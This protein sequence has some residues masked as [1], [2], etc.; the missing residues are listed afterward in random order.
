[1]DDLSIDLSE[2]RHEVLRELGEIKDRMKSLEMKI[3]GRPT[4]A[5]PINQD[6]HLKAFHD[7]DPA[8]T[9][10]VAVRRQEIT[11]TCVSKPSAH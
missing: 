3:C 7:Y 8:C 5:I 10:C 6:P 11:E 9:H 1:M 2:H 4:D